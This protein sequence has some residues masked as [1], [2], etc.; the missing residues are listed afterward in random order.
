VSGALYLMRH[1][2]AAPEGLLLGQADVPLLPEG[3]AQAERRSRELSAVTFDLA[4]CSPLRRSRQTAEIVLSG[5]AAN[6]S[7][8]TEA[9]DLREISLGRW[10]GMDKRSILAAFPDAW[11][12][13]GRDML[14]TPAPGGESFADLAAR[15]LPAFAAIRRQTAGRTVLLVAHQAVNRVILSHARGLPLAE[16]FTIPQ[17]PAALTLLANCER[18]CLRRPGRCPGPRRGK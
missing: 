17:P 12:A 2:T 10:E 7:S 16:L 18:Q 9:P 5:N 13:R 8:L 1:G 14:N 15:V 6:V 4:F 3:V 11:E